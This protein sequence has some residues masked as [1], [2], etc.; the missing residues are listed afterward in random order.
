MAI[1]PYCAFLQKQNV[2][3]PISGV[4]Q[5]EIRRLQEG[6]LLVAYSEIEKERI[7]ASNF[8]N[9]A[10]EFHKVVHA[11]FSQMAVVPFR[12]PTRL[13]LPELGEH[14]RQKSNNYVRFLREHADDVQIEL[15]ILLPAEN[16]ANAATGT[17]HLRQRSASFRQVKET[18]ERA[19]EMLHEDVREWRE[20]EIPGGLR[21]YALVSREH[22]NGV[23]EKLSRRKPEISLRWSGPW[24]ATEFLQRMTE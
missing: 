21:L 15:R 16:V 10:L 8:K 19:R 7:S 17:E 12:F 5:S 4:N 23:R 20:R 6:E 22:V 3:I 1:L 24:P 2:E 11:F 18:A 14:L 9:A 13:S